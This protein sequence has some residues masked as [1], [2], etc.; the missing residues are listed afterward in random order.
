MA[1]K[2]SVVIY[3]DRASV[4]HKALVVGVNNLNPDV[5]DVAYFD[6]KSDALKTEFGVPHMSDES[7]KETNP[8]LPQYSLNCWKKYGEEHLAIPVDHPANDHPF[9]LK[10]QDDTGRIVAKA[11][12]EFDK[13]IADVAASTTEVAEE[14]PR[15]IGHYPV[16]ISG[17]FTPGGPPD[18][19]LPMGTGPKDEAHAEAVAEEIHEAIG[20]KTEVINGIPMVD[21]P[22]IQY[23]QPAFPDPP[24]P[25]VTTQ[26]DAA[27][28]APVEEKKPEDAA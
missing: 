4:K 12:P 28:P 10:K 16:P 19:G 2:A 9:E 18:P 21:E 11:R 26:L 6:L 23:L 20:A 27:G 25:D 13:H 15:G 8:E 3:I 14:L 1:E 24:E 7:K 22:P 5:L 17:G